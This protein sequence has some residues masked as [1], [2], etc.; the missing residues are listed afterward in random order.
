[1]EDLQ[2]PWDMPDLD[3]NPSKNMTLTAC[4]VKVGGPLTRRNLT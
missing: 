1:M 4:P 2:G 3:S